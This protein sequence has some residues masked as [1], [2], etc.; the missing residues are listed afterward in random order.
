MDLVDLL[1]LDHALTQQL[2]LVHHV[3]V[4]VLLDFLQ[5]WQPLS[6]PFVIFL[7]YCWEQLI[8]L[9]K[10]GNTRKFSTLCWTH[11]GCTGYAMCT[12]RHNPIKVKIVRNGGQSRQAGTRR[13]LSAKLWVQVRSKFWE[14]KFI[15]TPAD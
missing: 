15:S 9:A 13:L 4:L 8:V 1:L 3:R 12:T 5:A 7:V 10:Y 2:A 11:R 14:Q 6:S